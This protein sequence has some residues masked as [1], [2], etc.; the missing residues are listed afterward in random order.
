MGKRFLA[1]KRRFAV[2]EHLFS[3]GCSV[4][5]CYVF[6]KRKFI[7]SFGVAPIYRKWADQHRH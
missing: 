5:N 7:P 1:G 3:A 2:F 4:A 6:I